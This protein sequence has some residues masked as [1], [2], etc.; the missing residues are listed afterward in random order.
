MN[1][2]M[3]CVTMTWRWAMDTRATFW[4]TLDYHHR[5]AGTSRT[6]DLRR[7]LLLSRSC[8]TRIRRRL[9]VH[10]WQRRLGQ[11]WRTRCRCADRKRRSWRCLRTRRPS[12]DSCSSRRPRWTCCTRPRTTPSCSAAARRTSACIDRPCSADGSARCPARSC[13]SDRQTQFET[14]SAIGQWNSGRHRTAESV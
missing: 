10:S 12:A 11:T 5:T 9:T 13:R 4:N 14:Y 7:W 8:C 2:T 3:R 6:S 1:D